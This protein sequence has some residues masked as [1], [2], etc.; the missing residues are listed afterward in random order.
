LSNKFYLAEAQRRRDFKAVVLRELC[1]SAVHL[2]S[3]QKALDAQQPLNWQCAG[4]YTML[5]KVLDKPDNST[6][7]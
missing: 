3:S 1:V 4:Q 6:R 7:A 2:Y 5:S